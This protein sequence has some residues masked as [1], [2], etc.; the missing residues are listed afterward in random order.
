MISRLFVISN[1]RRT[2]VGGRL[3][4]TITDR[5]YELDLVPVMDV[6]VDRTDLITYYER[7]GWQGIGETQV[8]MPNGIPFTVLAMVHGD[9]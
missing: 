3:L 8:W 2:G 9:S 6:A 1:A 5:A 7:H 4:K